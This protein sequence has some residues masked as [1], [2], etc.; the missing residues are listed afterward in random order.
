MAGKK[1]NKDQEAT[2]IDSRFVRVVEAFVKDRSVNRESRKGFGSGALK[3]NG[4]IFAM[5]SSEG[6]FVVKLPKDRVDKLVSSGKG[7]RFDPGHG[8]IMK[9]W[10]VVGTRQANWIELAKEARQFVKLGKS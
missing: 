10:V 2:E 7:E 9:E 6:K 8:R 5:M 4:K 1:K 3:V